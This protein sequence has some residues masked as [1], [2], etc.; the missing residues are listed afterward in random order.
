MEF[1]T[2][3][4]CSFRTR[5]GVIDVLMDLPGVG[6]FDVVRRNAR[7]YEWQRT[8]I[9]VAAIDDIITSKE[10]ADRA[11][12]RRALDALYAARNHLREHADDYELS[13]RAPDPTRE[14]DET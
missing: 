7:R 3:V 13:E 11:K 10:T 9:S 5:F 1:R 14:P 2:E 4:V 12:D 6:G 8:V